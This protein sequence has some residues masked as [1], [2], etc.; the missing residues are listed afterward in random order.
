VSTSGVTA[1]GEGAAAPHPALDRRR[2]DVARARGRTRRLAI[3]AAAA[4]LGSA[5]V[6]FWL[7]TGPLL[8]VRDVRVSQYDRPDAGRLQA[9][10]AAAADRGGSLLV[11]PIADIRAAAVRFPWVDDVTVVRDLPLG[12]VVQITKAAPV[13][14]AVPAEGAAVLVSERGLVMGPAAGARGLP[15]FRIPGA[16]PAYGEPVPR[17]AAPAMRFILLSRP[18]TAAR[19]RAL[20]MEGGSLVGMLPGGVTL[21]LGPPTRLPAKARS[22]QAVLDWMA[23]TPAVA[24]QATYL[25]LAIPEHPALG[26]E[27]LASAAA[28]AVAAAGGAPAAGEEAASPALAGAGAGAPATGEG[29]E[30]VPSTD[31]TPGAGDA[32]VPVGEA[33]PASP[34]VVIS[35]SGGG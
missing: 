9:A 32:A 25:D 11:P 4:G 30:T 3:V 24:A 31:P 21:R 17:A 19:F 1:P 35:P 10:V 12:V 34:E 29:A 7:A 20:R 5:V 18:Q 23:K 2:R 27:E 16:P 26:T 8:S 14:V 6:G 15:R 13:G 33:V 22:L 28:S